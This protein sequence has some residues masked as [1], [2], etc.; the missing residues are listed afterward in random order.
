MFGFRRRLKKVVRDRTVYM[1]VYGDNKVI[2][3]VVAGRT[4]FGGEEVHTYGIE[5]EERST[6]EKETIQ[7]FS[8]NI[9]DAVD[10][11][12]MLINAR[13]RPKQ[14]YTKALGYLCAAI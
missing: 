5:A 2:Y 13:A 8:R 4:W 10:F 1:E 11:A 6:G 12:E 7:D 14:L 3:R 9:E